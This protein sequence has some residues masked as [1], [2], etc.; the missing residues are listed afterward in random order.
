ML[1]GVRADGSFFAL[2]VGVMNYGCVRAGC[3]RGVIVKL[4]ARSW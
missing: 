2:R 1:G 4:G 3:G